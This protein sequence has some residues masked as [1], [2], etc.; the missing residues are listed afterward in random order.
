[1]IPTMRAT[2]ALASLVCLGAV[3]QTPAGGDVTWPVNGGIDNIRYSPLAEINRTN[4]GRLEVAW[5][6]D[7]HDA[8]RASEMQS[9]PIV[10][11]GVLYATTPTLK[12]VA[13]DAETGREIWKFDPS[14]GAATS[15]RFRHRGVTVHKERVFVSYRSFL[16]ALDR[17]TGKPIASFGADGRIDLRE[18]LDQPAAGLSVSASTPGTIFEDMLI[19]GS[20]VPETLPGS[21]GH[22]RAVDVNTGKVRWIFHTIPKPGEFGYDTWPE[23]AYKKAGGVHNSFDVLDPAVEG[24]LGKVA[25]RQSASA[26]VVTQ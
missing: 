16:Y 11:D 23:G 7:S 9:N 21:P 26:R 14:G 12:V 2:L 18:G 13:I 15:P 1:M 22:I 4:V 20:S 10:V 3:F 8:F 25:I 24:E 17:A 5:T 19:M 6:Y